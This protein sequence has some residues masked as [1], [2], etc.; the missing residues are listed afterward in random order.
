MVLTWIETGGPEVS[1]APAQSGTGSTI[2]DRMI[3]AA[4]GAID[5]Q[6]KPEGLHAVLT[7]PIEGGDAKAIATGLAF[8]GQAKFSPDSKRIAYISDRDGAENLWI[9][10]ADGSDPRQLTRDKQAQYTSPSW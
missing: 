2:M 10:N 6:W 4:R 5:R 1:G 3:A 7:V 8:E 9:A